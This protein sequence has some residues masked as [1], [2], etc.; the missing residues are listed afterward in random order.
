MTDTRDSFIVNGRLVGL[1]TKWWVWKGAAPTASLYCIHG[2]RLDAQCA[3]CD[4]AYGR[5]A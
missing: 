5:P 4:R 3:R 1:H 2:K